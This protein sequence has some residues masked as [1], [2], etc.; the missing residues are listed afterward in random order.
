M[1]LPEAFAALPFSQPARARADLELLRARL[2]ERLYD[3]LPTVL[4]QVPDP[5]GA[6]NRLER[7]SRE[8]GRRV[9]EA[10]VRQ[11]ALLHYLLALFSHSRFLSETLLQQPDLIVWLGREKHLE[12]LKSKEEL[13][14][15]YARFETAALDIEPALALAR[16]KRRQYLRITLKD[17]LGLATLVETTLELSTLADVL[18]AKALELAEREL[19]QRY[20]TPQTTDTR[21]RPVP[22]RFA[23]VSLGKLGGSELNY[24]SDVDLLFLHAGEG[25]TS[26]P[27]SGRRIVNSEFFLRL[28]QRLLQIIAGVTREGPVFRV[29]LRLRP[30]GGEGDLAISLPTAI[31]YYR[32]HAREWELQMLLKARSSAG[33]ASLVREFLAAVEPFLFRGEMHFAAVESV[34]ESREGLDRKLEGGAGRQDIKRAPGGIR[35]I[36]FLVQC[37]QRLH[38]QEDRWVRA[39]GTLLG[40]QKLYDKGYLTAR[41]HSHLAAAYEFLRRVEH[42]LQLEQGQQTHTLPEDP[43]ALALLARRCGL[44]V[45]PGISVGGEFRRRLY[46]HLRQ[47]RAI[48][49]RTLPGAV[50]VA[51]REEFSLRVSELLTAPSELAY[52][53]MVE[54]LCAHGSALGRE[55]ASLEV[56]ERVRKPFHRFLAATLASS[57]TF[58]EINH[59]AAALPRAV[60]ILRLSEPLGSLLIRRPERLSA[61]LDLGGA[62]TATARR[63]LTISPPS[64]SPADL[65]PRLAVLIERPGS[66]AEQMAGLRDYFNDAVFRWGARELCVE[67][68]LEA[69]LHAYTLLAEEIL[70]AALAIAEQRCGD[71]GSGNASALAVIALG[72][73]GTVEMDWGSDADLVF[74]VPDS[75]LQAQG[76]RVAEKFLHV[77]SGYTREGTIFPVDVRLRPRGGEGELVQTSASVSDYFATAAEVWEGVTYLKARPVAGDFPLGEQVCRRIRA[78]LAERFR[79]DGRVRASLLEMRRRLEEAGLKTEGSVD[80][81]KTGAGGVY[82]LDF[83][84][85]R[86]ALTS[87]AVS[88]AGRSLGE[89]V[90]EWAAAGCV[91]SQ[92]R[93]C[94]PEAA[95]RLRA[96]DHAIRLVVG[97]P[98]PQLPTGPRG[99][100]VAELVG[101]W[102]DETLNPSALAARLTETRRAVRAA[103]TR[104][105]E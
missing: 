47:V 38:G 59:T 12:R 65:R 23:V 20:G 33:E 6:L 78:A 19:R 100:A 13:L 18:L 74:V 92:E 84:V 62:S 50:Q 91:S 79:E 35:D 88:L 58:E 57:A 76:R 105:F 41:D 25:E 80:N 86:A 36:E 90:E 55:L 21:G 26:A 42:R 61:L 85:S 70:R 51:E 96:I 102:L 94:L 69:G 71:M 66:L 49:E 83:I 14:E 67:K 95:R 60:E 37:L 32:R 56:P 75:E 81:F 2:P 72:R 10:M 99:E 54:R 30:G 3:R 101:R 16:F 103:F 34:L 8:A 68:A 40:L 44:A 22:A 93:Q 27:E 104:A 11:P 45:S 4:A 24:S 73:L 5:D 28:A 48:Y 82:D 77:V 63:Q 7:F 9:L 89:Q 64:G 43:E 97:R 53:E 98:S 39:A 31:D 46:E 87:E 1:S 29:D 15:D 17:I 52:R